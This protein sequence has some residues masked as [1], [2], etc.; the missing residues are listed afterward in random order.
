MI[1]VVHTR[2]FRNDEFIVALRR[3]DFRRV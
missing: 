2:R 3:F 1:I